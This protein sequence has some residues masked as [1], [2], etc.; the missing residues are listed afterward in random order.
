VLGRLVVAKGYKLALAQVIPATT[1]PEESFR[2]L[3][4][5]ELR[6]ARTIRALVPVPYAAS[7]LQVSLL[8]CVLAL[9]AAHGAPWAWALFVGALIARAVAARRIDKALRLAKA[10]DAWLFLLRD[11]CSFLIYIAS[12]TG[13]RVDWRGQAMHADAGKVPSR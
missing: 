7:V 1:V 5:H 6:W 4:R 9:I 13:S 10:G 8:W 3:F 11:F 12:F 2:A